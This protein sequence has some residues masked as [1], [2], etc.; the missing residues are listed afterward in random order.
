MS[1]YV[2][3]S[4]LFEEDTEDTDPFTAWSSELA[5]PTSYS[6]GTTVVIVTSTEPTTTS[7]HIAIDSSTTTDSPT[8]ATSEI[9][10]NES[11][12]PYVGTDS[13]KA[14]GLSASAS[15]G[16]GIGVALGILLLALVVFILYRRKRKH[17]GLAR[18]NDDNRPA[19]PELGTDGQKHELS[20]EE[21]TRV[22]LGADEPKR[23]NTN[24]QELE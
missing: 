8:L 9:T 14:G 18:G 7:S 20:A 12:T 6:Q 11:A 2:D 16:I 19:L 13:T 15:A 10:S 5:T 3:Y 4:D 21:C 23:N 17:R 22:E 24:V 1:R